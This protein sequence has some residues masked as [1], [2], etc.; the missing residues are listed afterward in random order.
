[1]SDLHIELDASVFT[2]D[3]LKFGKV[4]QLVVDPKNRSLPAMIVRY[5]HL[6]EERDFIVGWQLIENIDQ[7]GVRLLIDG[8]GA[9]K[10][11]E[12][13]RAANVSGPTPTGGAYVG[14]LGGAGAYAQSDFI[15]DSVRAGGPVIGEGGAVPV[16]SRTAFD[17]NSTNIEMQTNLP[18]NTLMVSHDTEVMTNDE[19]TIGKVHEVV[20]NPVGV[21]QGFVGRAGRIRHHTIYVPAELIASGSHRAVRLKIS[22]DEAERTLNVSA[23]G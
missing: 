10:L 16:G 23:P 7:T 19:K 3:G 4:H 13:I 6:P 12:V 22:A 8:R 20:C 14:Y 18:E 2:S 15:G 11:Q 9:E 1:M 17:L 5:G 21:I